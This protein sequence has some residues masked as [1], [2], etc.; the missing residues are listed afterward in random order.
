MNKL[1]DNMTKGPVALLARYGVTGLVRLVFDWLWTKAFFPR[2]RLLRRPY[3][4]R[5]RRHI[6][7]GRN[8][9]TGVGLRLDAFPS[10]S[11]HGNCIVIGDNTQFN[12]Y[13]HVGAV[14][15][16]TI[17]NGV[18]VASKVFITDHNHGCYKGSGDQ[19]SPDT[20]P[21]MRRLDSSPVVIEDNVWIGELV[22]ILPGV[23]IGRGSVIGSM[24]VVTQDIPADCIAVGAPAHVIKKYDRAKQ[25]WLPLEKD[26]S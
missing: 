11:H 25:Q 24:S 9:T 8:F 1:M 18:L 10:Q 2:A 5:G 21:I 12:D 23:R 15:S 4:M 13:V 3:Y 20:P 14:K 17:G 7:I 19:D 16:V 6:H 22:T 26:S